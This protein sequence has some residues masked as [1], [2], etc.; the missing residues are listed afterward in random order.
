MAG[1]SQAR[2]GRMALSFILEKFDACS[3]TLASI[4]AKLDIRI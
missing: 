4:L 1:T 2:D 3:S